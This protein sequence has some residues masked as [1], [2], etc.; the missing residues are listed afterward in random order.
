MP[1]SETA[2]QVVRGTGIVSALTLVSRIFG[3]IR[4]VIIASV[5]GVSAVAD[6]FV[7][8]FRIPNILRSFIAEGALTSAFIP[9]FSDAAEEG[10]EEAKKVF[11]SVSG[12]LLSITTSLSVIGI[13]LAP[14]VVALLAPGFKSSPEQFELCIKLTRIMFPFIIFVSLVAMCSGAMN[15]LRIFGFAP[16]AQIVMNLALIAGALL[17][18]SSESTQSAVLVLAFVVPIGGILQLCS[19]IPGLQRAG[20]LSLPSLDVWTKSTKELLKLFFPA[21]LGAS[22][23]QVSIVLSTAFASLL[24]VGSVSW[25]FWAD[26]LTQLPIGVFSIALASV[27]LPTLATAHSKGDQAEFNQSLSNALRYVSFV[28]IPTAIGIALIA[29]PLVSLVYERRE[30]SPADSAST[31]LAVQVIC[32]GI[33]GISCHS[34]MVRSFIARKDTVTPTI[35]GVLTLA[36]MST[37]AVAFMGD[38][39]PEVTGLVADLIRKARN[40]IGVYSA[41]HVGLAFAT[42]FAPSISFLALALLSGRMMPNFSWQPFFKATLISILASAG[43]AI[44]LLSLSGKLSPILYLALGIPAAALSYAGLSF[45][46]KSSESKETFDAIARFIS[47]RS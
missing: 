47:R 46:L 38:P 28:M 19:Q 39:R 21:V 45:L 44:V 37:L 23:Y 24:V 20:I 34:M 15:T 4:D 16:I 14:S 42:S 13:L 31:S 22:V 35:I 12:L 32:F 3:L 25:L 27:L 10:S 41:G 11:R 7:V 29:P 9:V 2:K 43:M 6:A 26:R 40:L 18:S 8:A 17:A 30:F 5:I 36:V 33:W 1:T